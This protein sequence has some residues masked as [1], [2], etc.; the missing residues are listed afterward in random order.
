MAASQLFDKPSALRGLCAGVAGKRYNKLQAVRCYW[1][2]MWRAPL[3]LIT[4]PTYPIPRVY[5]IASALLKVQVYAC[6]NRIKTAPSPSPHVSLA[7]SLAPE[8][9]AGNV[10]MSPARY[11]IKPLSAD[12]IGF[13]CGHSLV[14]ISGE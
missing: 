2:E 8:L 9:L 13:Y 6:E 14:S 11:L 4:L 7:H 5:F 12:V 10:R 1:S 3:T